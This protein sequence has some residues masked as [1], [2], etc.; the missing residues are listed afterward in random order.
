MELI[1]SACQTAAMEGAVDCFVKL[2]SSIRFQQARLIYFYSFVSGSACMLC[3]S[4]FYYPEAS[5]GAAIY[6]H[7]T[8]MTP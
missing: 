7:I 4:H 8:Q 3:R 2:I 5:S 6:S 1:P